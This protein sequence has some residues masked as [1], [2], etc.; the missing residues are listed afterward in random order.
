M[1]KMLLFDIDGTLL[2]TG[3]VGMAA[4]EKAFQELHG[5]RDCWG[6]TIPDGKTD[7]LLFEEISAVHLQRPLTDREYSRLYERYLFYFRREINKTGC[8]RLMPGVVPLLESLGQDSGILLGIATGNFEEAAWLKL[9]RGGLDH[10][11]RFGGFGS[12]ARD[13]VQL[14]QIAIQRGLDRTGWVLPNENIYVIGDS[15][16]DMEAGN[17]LGIQTIGVATGKTSLRELA[18][19]NPSYLFEDFSDAQKFLSIIRERPTP[20]L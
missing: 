3:G 2:I 9:K 6:D 11:F 1:T 8:F 13:R 15:I 14:L 12:D 4:F 10:Y 16:R 19:M 5:I 20:T 18:A 7:P 17:Q